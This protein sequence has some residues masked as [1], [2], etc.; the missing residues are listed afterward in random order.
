MMFKFIDRFAPV[1][2]FLT[3]VI[4][5]LTL[6][7]NF[8]VPNLPDS[9]YTASAISI[10]VTLILLT[11]AGIGTFIHS[12]EVFKFILSRLIAT[13]FILFAFFLVI[14]VIVADSA[15]FRLTPLDIKD[16]Q[17]VLGVSA[18]GLLGGQ[19]RYFHSGA[20][21]ASENFSL[22]QL[23]HSSIVGMFVAL[24]LFLVLRAGIIQQSSVDT[25]NIWGVV[26]VTAVTGFFADNVLERLS[27]VYDELIGAKGDPEK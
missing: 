9:F 4:A 13:I 14:L 11:G 3:T 18:A 5:G 20:S 23:V 7:F 15:D 19:M 25:F 21:N 26:G 27:S 16:V 10:Y 8:Y 24:V 1:I 12:A 17:I 6:T 22:W 2:A